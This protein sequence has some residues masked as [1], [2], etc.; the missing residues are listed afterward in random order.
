MAVGAFVSTAYP[1]TPTYTRLGATYCCAAGP[2]IA[3]S[4]HV[5]CSAGGARKE[6]TIALR[7]LLFV[8]RKRAGLMMSGM[9][10]QMVSVSDWFTGG[11]ANG[12]SVRLATSVRPA[13]V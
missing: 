13:V 1:I 4:S 10:L 7:Q 11:G 5:V 9:L 8:M 6:K 12:I 2:V 3:K